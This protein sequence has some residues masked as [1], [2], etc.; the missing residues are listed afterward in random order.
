MNGKIRLFHQGTEIQGLNQHTTVVS[1]AEKIK[2]KQTAV[3]AAPHSVPSVEVNTRP[4]S[5]YD[6]LVR[7]E[8]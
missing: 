3:V 8:S 4:L 7:G 1:L 6:D 2:R 5:A